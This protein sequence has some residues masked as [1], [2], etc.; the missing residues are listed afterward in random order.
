MRV[1]IFPG[2]IQNVNID[3]PPIIEV[4]RQ[5][6]LYIHLYGIHNASYNGV[7]NISIVSDSQS[8]MLYYDSSNIIITYLSY[9]VISVYEIKV[10]ASNHVS[11]VS[12]NFIT[13]VVRKS[14]HQPLVTV[15]PYFVLGTNTTLL[16]EFSIVTLSQANVSYENTLWRKQFSDVIDTTLTNVCILVAICDQIYKKDLPHTSN[17]LT[18]KIRNFP[19][20]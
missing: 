6:V 1:F 5:T 17:F 11:N 7:T 20:T 14:I 8:I 4:S 18:L 9:S 12:V 15:L 3:F 10:I 16:L 19:S 2:L 13:E